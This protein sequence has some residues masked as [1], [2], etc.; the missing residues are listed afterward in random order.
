M[1]TF[2]NFFTPREYDAALPSEPD[3]S[4]RILLQT[5]DYQL[6]VDERVVF[7]EQYLKYKTVDLLPDDQKATLKAM[8]AKLPTFTKAMV[9]G[10]LNTTLLKLG[11]G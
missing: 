7:T 6:P 2:K 4:L 9:E 8:V 3:A 10:K 11:L 1:A 5:V